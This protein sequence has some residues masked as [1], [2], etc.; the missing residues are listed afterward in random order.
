MHFGLLTL[1][2]NVANI[3]LISVWLRAE[4][5]NDPF[6]NVTALIFWVNGATEKLAYTAKQPN[7]NPLM[8]NSGL[9]IDAGG[10]SDDETIE[11]RLLSH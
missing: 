10:I 6:A 4:T 3:L 7:L 1:D 5:K 9:Q 11:P 8:L 2:G